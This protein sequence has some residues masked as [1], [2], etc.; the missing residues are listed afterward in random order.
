VFCL[1]CESSECEHSA[2]P[3]SRQVFIGYSA[4]GVPR[5]QDF[6]QWLLERKHPGLDRVYRQPPQMV[7]AVVSGRELSG[8]LLP[9]F[10]DLRHDYRIHGQVTAGWFRI[11]GPDGIPTV[12]ALSFQVLSSVR[13]RADSDDRRASSARKGRG[14]RRDGKKRPERRRMGLNVLGAGPSGEPLATLHD[15]LDPVPWTS[16][17]QW[18]HSVL[19]S[20]ERSQGRKSATP[21]QLSAR[22]EGV[23][24]SIA[25][26]LEQGRRAQ[27]RRTSHAE[28]RHTSG[29]RPTRMARSDL[30]RAT[31]ESF[32]VDVRR[33]TMIV[34]GERGRAHVWNPQGKL[35]TSVRYGA[36]AIAR[37]KKQEIW[38]PAREEEIAKL[39]NTVGGAG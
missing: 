37:K 22:V 34:L 12:L 21:E 30:D 32:L 31:A 36:E 16:V 4:N 7:T 19:S 24:G 8:Q 29:D 39:R 14:P 28:K 26:R 38:R 35:V 5:F 27:D 11:P 20:I 18:G 33:R 2:P 1:R 9:A 23:L 10:Q 6:G 25:R 17:V 3:D 15:R 13:R